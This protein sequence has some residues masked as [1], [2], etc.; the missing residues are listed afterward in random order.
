MSYQSIPSTAAAPNEGGGEQPL[1][2]SHQ[3]STSSSAD[4][5]DDDL[6]R[7]RRGVVA[8]VTAAA[9]LLCLAFLKYH[10]SLSFLGYG[11]L[12]GLNELNDHV[13]NRLCE[14]YHD[15]TSSRLYYNDKKSTITRDTVVRII[16]T[17]FGEPSQPWREVPC[18]HRYNKNNNNNNHDRNHG[19]YYY[20]RLQSLLSSQRRT[21]PS[22]SEDVDSDTIS[23]QHH[24]QRPSAVINVDFTNIIFPNRQPILGFG[25]AFTEASALNF[26]SLNEHGRKAALEL[27]F[28]KDG[29]GYRYVF[30]FVFERVSLF[31]YAMRSIIIC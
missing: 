21:L 17:S 13:P 7:R 3:E 14:I 15:P 12:D 8:A 10:S 27:L 2:L 26:W 28:G 4:N 23:Q 24:Q 22:S 18:V 20:R 11:N 30:A 5:N 9:L 19:R 16:E 6:S 1:E 29:L 31:V 25:G